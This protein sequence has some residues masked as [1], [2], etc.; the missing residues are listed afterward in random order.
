MRWLLGSK[1]FLIYPARRQNHIVKE[2]SLSPAAP[3]TIVPSSTAHLVAVGAA[4]GV[5]LSVGLLYIA[6]G[7]AG[8]ALSVPLQTGVTE[9]RSQSRLS[10][11]F[12]GSV[13]GHKLS[14]QCAVSI[15]C[16]TA[17]V[18]GCWGVPDRKRGDRALRGEDAARYVGRGADVHFCDDIP[19]KIAIGHV[20]YK[21]ITCTQRFGIAGLVGH[22]K[23]VG[24][25]L[26]AAKGPVFIVDS[27]CRR[28]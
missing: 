18:S 27:V 6:Y 25:R 10:A 28:P 9:S 22:R 4:W 11:A 1:T 24:R 3:Y 19:T 17:Q 8:P 2:D 21:S 26:C 7:V 12:H 20:S 5:A 13:R 16:I 14:R 23:R 15:I